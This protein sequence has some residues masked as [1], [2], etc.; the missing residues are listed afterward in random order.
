M[1]DEELFDEIGTALLARRGWHFEPATTPGSF[2]SWCLDPGGDVAVAVN[3]ID[4]K[5]VAYL[6]SSD[7]EVP[8]DGVVGL[9]EWLD[10]REGHTESG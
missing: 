7:R 9:L 8:L 1:T 3:V 10:R 4:G 5:V 6:P 2:P